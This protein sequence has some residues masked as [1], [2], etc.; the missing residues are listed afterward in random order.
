MQEPR[1]RHDAYAALRIPAFLWLLLGSQVVS[2][3]TA[4]QGLAVGWEI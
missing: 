2:I 1:A 4:A 3:G